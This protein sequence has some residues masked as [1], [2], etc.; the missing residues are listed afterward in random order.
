[1]TQIYLIGHNDPGYPPDEP[2][3]TV[4]TWPKVI[5]CVKSM[6]QSYL[7]VEVDEEE[8]TTRDILEYQRSVF[9]MVPNSTRLIRG[10]AF[11]VRIVEEEQI[12]QTTE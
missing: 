2:E 9:N 7:L 1:M 8:L 12:T 4:H 6:I 11:Y 3:I 10:H 5:A